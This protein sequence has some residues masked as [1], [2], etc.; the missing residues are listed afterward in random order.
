MRHHADWR[1]PGGYT[2]TSKIKFEVVTVCH[3]L[4][5]K[6]SAI[7]DRLIASAI[8]QGL[9]ESESDIKPSKMGE[10]VKENIQKPSKMREN[11]EGNGQNAQKYTQMSQSGEKNTQ[12]PAFPTITIKNVF[13]LI[14]QQPQIKQ[15]QMADNLGVDDSTIERA[16]VWLKE[17]GYINKEH[18]KVKGV[19]QLI[20]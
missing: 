2:E 17:N 11:D 1:K 4:N 20:K 6:T 5:I 3:G 13:D 14:C 9:I 8:E 18:S 7:P 15:A 10:N 16:T 19:W 12:R